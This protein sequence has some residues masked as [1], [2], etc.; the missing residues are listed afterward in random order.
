MREPSGL[1][2]DFQAVR[3]CIG[4]FRV[5]L[6]GM[7][8]SLN[9]YRLSRALRCAGWSF[10][11]TGC[12]VLVAV[13]APP[14]KAA[15]IKGNAR[16]PVFAPADPFDP[17]TTINAR[18]PRA[19]AMPTPAAPAVNSA[20]SV[21]AVPEPAVA[22]VTENSD[23]PERL[24]ERTMALFTGLFSAEPETKISADEHAGR[25]TPQPPQIDLQISLEL[26]Q[27]PVLPRP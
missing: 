5:I 4:T 23:S 20:E 27:Q 17:V 9:K 15:D 3:M 1:P 21:A 7:R 19:Q 6:S 13:I 12:L 16:Q 10:L 14:A 26:D 2:Y 24:Y 22:N 25:D 8:D 11:T 18:F